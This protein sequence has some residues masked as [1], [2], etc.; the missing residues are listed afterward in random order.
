MRHAFVV[1]QIVITTV[2]LSGCELLGGKKPE[3]MSSADL[4]AARAQFI[5]ANPTA[6]PPP[7]RLTPQNV[8]A[9]VADYAKKNP[10]VRDRIAENNPKV[11]DYIAAQKAPT[12]P[13]PKLQ[14]EPSRRREQ[15]P[16][17]PNNG[18]AR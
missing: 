13:P 18:S 12:A 14:P 16:T 3:Q 8:G 6:P 2:A 15:P 11:A 1:L 10:T 17:R 4:A 9:V 7:V 5:A